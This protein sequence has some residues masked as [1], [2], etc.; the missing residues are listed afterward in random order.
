MEM[1]IAGWKLLIL[2]YIGIVRF[3]HLCGPRLG[4]EWWLGGL[5]DYVCFF[6]PLSY[7]VDG[8]LHCGELSVVCFGWGVPSVFIPA[9][10]LIMHRAE[11]LKSRTRKLRFAVAYIVG[12]PAD[13]TAESRSSRLHVFCSRQFIEVFQSRNHP[14]TGRNQDHL[15][16]SEYNQKRSA[17]G[18]SL[19]SRI[20]NRILRTGNRNQSVRFSLAKFERLK[21]TWIL[22]LWKY[23]P[24]PPNPTKLAL[25]LLNDQCWVS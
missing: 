3:W 4:S 7:G 17:A 16:V 18:P 15:R 2:I 8:G 14:Y 25:Q 24:L 22:C 21:N 13:L 9:A 20:K 5:D 10:S 12:W 1:G 23:Q 11:T 19:C 6:F